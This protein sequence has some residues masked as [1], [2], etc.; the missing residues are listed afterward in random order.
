MR[1][2]IFLICLSL[3]SVAAFAVID[4]GPNSIGIYFDQQAESNYA[5]VP[6]LETFAAYVILTNPTESTISAVEYRH[7]VVVQS[8]VLNAVLPMGISDPCGDGCI[9]GGACGDQCMFEPRGYFGRDNYQAFYVFGQSINAQP[10]TVLMSIHFVL[11]S[12]ATLEF[13]LGPVTEFPST[14]L[15]DPVY[16][17]AGSEPVPLGVSS[18]SFELPVAE[19]N[20]GHQPV[21]VESGT[22]GTVKSLYR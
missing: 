18:G 13:Y 12:E 15:G 22:W 7:E 21:V 1:N 19:V 8:D 17:G 2:I 16:Y 14:P 4:P 5:D 9:F 11:L 20:T 3:I 6:L 10:A